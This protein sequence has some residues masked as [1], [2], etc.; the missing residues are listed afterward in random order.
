VVLISHSSRYLLAPFQ[1]I[2]FDKSKSY[3]NYKIWQ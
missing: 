3:Q 1:S 2:S